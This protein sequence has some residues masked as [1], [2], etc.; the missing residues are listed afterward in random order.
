MACGSSN[1][2]GTLSL[3]EDG[4]I[5]IF[6]L[7]VKDDDQ[8]PE[9][10]AKLLRSGEMIFLNR[11]YREIHIFVPEGDHE[12]QVEYEKLKFQEG[13][14]YRWAQIGCYLSELI[15]SFKLVTNAPTEERI[16]VLSPSSRRR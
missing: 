16:R 1:I 11:G 6:F 14:P 2:L 8:S 3:I 12:R 4:R 9:I 13:N 7:V 15:L 10:R 5:A